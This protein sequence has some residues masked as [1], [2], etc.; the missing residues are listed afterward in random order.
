MVAGA[1]QLSC[2]GGLQIN[3]VF[4]RGAKPIESGG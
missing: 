2:L 4:E 3:E 1:L